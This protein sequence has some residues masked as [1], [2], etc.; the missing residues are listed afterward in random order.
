M[1]A[2]S[3]A[4]IQDKFALSF[5][6]IWSCTCSRLWTTPSCC[7]AWSLALH[8][9]NIKAD[10][11]HIQMSTHSRNLV[12]TWWFCWG[13]YWLQMDLQTCLNGEIKARKTPPRGSVIW[14]SSS[15]WKVR[16]WVVGVWF[17]STDP[18]GD[19][20]QRLWVHDNS[21]EPQLCEQNIKKALKPQ[22]ANE[23]ADIY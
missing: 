10:N 7:S 6:Y 18:A 1:W 22:D 14:L 15:S 12:R 16:Q 8:R 3:C 20:C 17:R 19:R 4:A 11:H 21:G 13:P 5:L 9:G 2:F 23:L